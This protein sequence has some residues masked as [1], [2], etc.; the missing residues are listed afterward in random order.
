MISS[1]IET[2]SDANLRLSREWTT[3]RYATL[4]YTTLHYT[5]LRY[6]TLRG[7]TIH[8]ISNWNVFRSLQMEWQ[9][10]CNSYVISGFLAYLMRNKNPHFEIY[11]ICNADKK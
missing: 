10:W 3:L 9:T 11:E 7:V 1:F 5:T 4:H 6:T 2:Y 8:K